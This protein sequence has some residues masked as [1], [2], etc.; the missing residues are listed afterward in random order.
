MLE[1]QPATAW[2]DGAVT[3][4][5]NLGALSESAAYVYVTDSEGH[6][7]AGQ[8]LTLGGGG[9]GGGGCPVEPEPVPPEPPTPGVSDFSIS[10]LPTIQTIH[11][12][13]TTTFDITDRAGWGLCWRGDAQRERGLDG[14]QR[15]LRSPVRCGWGNVAP[16]DC[17]VR[18]DP[19]RA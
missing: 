3:V 7:S 6:R 16:D 9:G 13:E 17:D 14:D 2:S 10:M 19:G 1:Y 12:A 5:L 18:L 8:A 15:E 11:V 4:T